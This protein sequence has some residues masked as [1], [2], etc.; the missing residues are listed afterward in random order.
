MVSGFQATLVAA[1]LILAMAAGYTSIGPPPS[2]VASIDHTHHT[3]LTQTTDYATGKKKLVR[4]R[5]IHD[6][7]R[8]PVRAVPMSWTWK[9]N[10][11]H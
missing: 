4:K 6:T 10:H 11:R 2:A 7:G 1:A 8:M 9:C 3:H 5:G